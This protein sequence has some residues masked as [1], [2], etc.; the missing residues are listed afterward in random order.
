[1]MHDI[2]KIGI[3]D[4]I[5]KKPT[6]LTEEDTGHKYIRVADMKDGEIVLL[7]NG[8]VTEMG[9][10]D[11]LMNLNGSYCKLFNMQ[12]EYYKEEKES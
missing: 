6:K 3:P 4:S 7:E 1:M 2:G 9:S 11:K 10:H 12:A 8:K 5:L